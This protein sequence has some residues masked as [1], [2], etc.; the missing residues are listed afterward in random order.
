M[1][2][3]EK[4]GSPIVT[5]NIRVSECA[6]EI[7]YRLVVDGVEAEEE[8]VFALRMPATFRAWIGRLPS[9]S[10]LQSSTQ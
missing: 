4:P 8:R 2:I 5:D 7:T 3:L 1:H 10:A 6:Q 9:P